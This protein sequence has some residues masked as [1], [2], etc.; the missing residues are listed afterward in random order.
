M[1]LA[2]LHE[3]LQS[4]ARGGVPARLL[5]IDDGWQ[6]TELDQPL[7]QPPSSRSLPELQST[8][9]EFLLA[10]LEML[11]MAARDIPAGSSLGVFGMTPF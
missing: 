4:L 1:H 2:G 6:C 10:E 3:G 11:A 5:I 7:R 8:S 9:E